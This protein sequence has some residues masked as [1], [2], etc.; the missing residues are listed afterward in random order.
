MR[1]FRLCLSLILLSAL[2]VTFICCST[3]KNIPRVSHYY[4]IDFNKY[5]QRG[6]LFTPER[7]S[8]DYESVGMVQYVMMPAANR[9]SV[10]GLNE[11]I[12]EPVSLTQALDSLYYMAHAMGAD[13]VINFTSTVE[14][15][16]YSFVDAPITISG[17]NLSGF[18]IRRKK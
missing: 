14:E 18:A 8:G 3:P 2:A 12:V 10:G 17:Y 13:A 4:K 15:K 9:V 6:F 11:W 16:T 7:Y 5:T 1:V